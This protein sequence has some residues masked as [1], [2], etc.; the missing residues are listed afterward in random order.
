MRTK[1]FQA[2]ALA[3]AALVLAVTW[4][5][6]AHGEE[7]ARI[8]VPAAHPTMTWTYNGKRYFSAKDVLA[9]RRADVAKSVNSVPKEPEPIDGRVRIVLADR[10]RLRALFPGRPPASQDVQVE[11]AHISEQEVVDA[12]RHAGTFESVSVVEQNDTVSPELGN[13]NYVVWY[14][15]RSTGANNV[16]K[17][18]GTWYIRGKDSPPTPVAFDPGVA[19]GAPRLA[20]FIK[21]IRQ[22]AIDLDSATVD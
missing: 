16:G 6:R 1:L 13:D 21:T 12:I 8:P 7:S 14:Q 17:W 11:N 15:V 3:T 2:G 5:A 20:A 9:A 10:D 4:G 18:I 22:A 19:K